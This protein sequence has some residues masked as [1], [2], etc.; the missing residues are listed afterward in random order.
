[1][2]NFYVNRIRAGKMAIEQVPPKWRS[3]VESALKEDK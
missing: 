2:V 3:E 1:M